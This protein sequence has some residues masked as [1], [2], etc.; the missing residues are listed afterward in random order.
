LA[1]I[2][3]TTWSSGILED[4]RDRP[5]QLGRTG[6]ARVETG[7]D[8]AAREAPA[9]EVRDERRE[10]PQERRLAGAGGAEQR[11]DLAGLELERDPAQCRRSGG[12][13]EGEIDDGG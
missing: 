10:C 6:R 4:R 11:D 2:V 8:D 9:V 3:I 1:T 12:V 13:R 5:C 7:D